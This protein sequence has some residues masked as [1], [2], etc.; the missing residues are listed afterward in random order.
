L[1]ASLEKFERSLEL[2][3]RAVAFRPDDEGTALSHAELLLRMGRVDDALDAYSVAVKRWP[4]SALSLNAYGYT[5][6]DRTD[7]FAEAEKLIQKAIKLDP[8]NPAIIDSLG[9]V[10]YKL[11][12]LDEAL[13]ELQRAYDGF[14]DH[15]VAAHLVEVL[16][17]MDRRAEAQELL[18]AALVKSPE[19]PLLDDVRTRFFP[20]SP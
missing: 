7:R 4:K 5:L 14:D 16:V 12:R 15:E 2:Y 6:A 18:D 11:G 10:L 17:A 19:S 20:D 3:D 13:T 8:D 9:W 1:F